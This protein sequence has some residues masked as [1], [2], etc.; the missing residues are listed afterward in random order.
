MHLDTSEQ[1]VEQHLAHRGFKN[2]AYEPDGNVPPD[3]LVNNAIAVEVRRLNQN[4]LDGVQTKGLEEDAIPLWKKT[5]KV[6]ESFGPSAASE[7]WFVFFRFGRPLAPWKIVEPKFRSALQAFAQRPVREA[8]T[9]MSE[10]SF[11]VDVFPASNPHPAMF[12]MAGC[13]DQESGGWLL[14]EMEK[15]ILHCASEKARKVSGVRSKYPQWWLA[16]VDHIGHGLD[17]FDR[18]MFRDQVSIEHNWDKIIIID[19]RDPKRYFEI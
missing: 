16:L 17:E 13:S 5:K 18:E 3:F 14:S 11:E 19:P 1:L 10:G 12:L 6:I 4:H 7:T 15:N 9:I 2:I 8:G